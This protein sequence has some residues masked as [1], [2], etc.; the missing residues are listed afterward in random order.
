M[1]DWWPEPRPW[2][3]AAM[4]RPATQRERNVM[5]ARLAELDPRDIARLRAEI[6][7]EIAARFTYPAFFDYRA[8]RLRVRPIEAAKR[9]E[10]ASF[11]QA[12]ILEPIAQADVSSSEVRRFLEALFLRYLE[13]NA[14]LARGPARRR[15]SSIRVE[16]PRAAADV[17]RGLV[18]LA[19]G[20]PGNFGAPRPLVS[21]EASA[22]RGGQRPVPWERIER[23]TE[24]VQA[25]LLR[26]AD[27]AEPPVGAS[28][29]AAAGVGTPPWTGGGPAS[30]PSN[31]PSWADVPMD[32]TAP[33][34]TARVRSDRSPFADLAAGSQSSMFG[35]SASVSMSEQPTGPQPIVGLGGVAP[36]APREPPAELLQLYSDYLRDL[37]PG[38]SATGDGNGG[39]GNP[40]Q[41]ANGWSAPSAGAPPSRPASPADMKT[42][43]LIFEQLS[44]Q[45]DAYI[46]LAARSY[47][48]RARGTDP[49]SAIDALRRSGHVDEADLRIAESILAISDRISSGGAATVEDY[50]QVLMLYLLYHRGRIGT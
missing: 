5:G 40:P 46:R 44:H 45:L 9:R 22:A 34:P 17:Q 49:A 42:D 10:I 29:G 20:A 21:W 6:G 25:A 7:E 11:V 31:A 16:V 18:A 50:R 27:G 39:F 14:A 32:G 19:A 4:P 41:G 8:G 13:L 47:G 12:I 43:R 26:G 15:L 33:L 3:R 38:A 36:A 23:D 35:A 30:R 48:V 37:Q 28:P 1:V 2:V 24:L